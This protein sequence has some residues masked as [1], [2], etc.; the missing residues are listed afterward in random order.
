MVSKPSKPESLA[1][2]CKTQ[3]AEPHPHIS[4]TSGVGLDFRGDSGTF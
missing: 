4:D 3:I 2:L 1:G